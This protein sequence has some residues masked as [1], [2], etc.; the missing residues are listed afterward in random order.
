MHHV[1]NEVE[2]RGLPGDLALLPVVESAFN[3]FA[4]S[5]SHASGLWQFIAPTGERLWPPA[6]LLPG[7]AP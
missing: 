4:Y 5:R 2:A 6:Q 1:V 3:P 7:P